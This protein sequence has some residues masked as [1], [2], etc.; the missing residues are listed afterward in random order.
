MQMLDDMTTAAEAEA[1]RQEARHSDRAHH[2][3][4]RVGGYATTRAGTLVDGDEP[5]MVSHA[6]MATV[7]RIGADFIDQHRAGTL[8]LDDHPDALRL[9][10]YL[11]SSTDQ[12]R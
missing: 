8:N 7:Q 12:F 6:L 3:A 1:L 2:L 9:I 5:V 11:T 10:A 4:L